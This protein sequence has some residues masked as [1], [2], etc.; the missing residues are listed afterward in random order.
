MRCALRSCKS[1]LR[2]EESK[3]LPTEDYGADGGHGNS[4]VA[5]RDVSSEFEVRSLK[6]RLPALPATCFNILRRRSPSGFR[7][8]GLPGTDRSG[9]RSRERAGSAARASA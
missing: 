7:A 8:D 6:F 2:S 4:W 9:R 3:T 5:L 1:D